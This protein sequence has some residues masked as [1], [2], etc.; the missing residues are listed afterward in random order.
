MKRRSIREAKMT[1][2]DPKADKPEKTGDMPSKYELY[3]SQFND[4]GEIEEKDKSFDS[5]E[6]FIEFKDELE[7][8]PNFL[9]IHRKVEPAFMG[10]MPGAKSE[11]MEKVKVK[12]SKLRKLRKLVEV[13]VK[14]ELHNL[15]GSHV[16][17]RAARV[18]KPLKEYSNP[19]ALETLKDVVDDYQVQMELL[20]DEHYGVDATQFKKLW[21]SISKRFD[22]EFSN[23]LKNMRAN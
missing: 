20:I 14:S 5:L 19:V 16:K 11:E 22:K 15:H 12:E 6:K 10:E 17:H 9:Q 18:Y 4:E 23:T 13:S 7:L 8:D 3:W 1:L 2:E 21:Y